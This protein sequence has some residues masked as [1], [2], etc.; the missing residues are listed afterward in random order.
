ME[1]KSDCITVGELFRN[2]RYTFVVP[3]FQRGYSWDDEQIG[4]FC[5]DIEETFLRDASDPSRQHFFGGILG[6]HGR[7]VGVSV[8]TNDVVDGQQRLTTFVLLA[9]RVIR[10]YEALRMRNPEL[11]KAINLRIENL[12]KQYLV[13]EDTEDMVPKEHDRLTLSRYDYDFFKGLITKRDEAPAPARHSHNRLLEA[14]KALDKMLG[15]IL[16]GAK[17]PREK[18]EQLVRLEGVLN[19]C[20]LIVFLATSDRPDAYRV[21]QIM[22]DRGLSLNEADLLRAHTLGHL[23]SAS[24]KRELQEAEGI[25]DN[26]QSDRPEKTKDFLRWYYAAWQGEAPRK[27]ALFDD[28]RRKFFPDRYDATQVVRE[29]RRFHKAV[30]I[31][32]DL[33]QGEWPVI[34]FSPP[35]QWQANRL[36]LLVSSLKHNQCMP[37]LYAACSLRERHFVELVDVL[38]KFFFRYKVICDAHVTPMLQAYLLYAKQICCKAAA[39]R[40]QM[41]RT[42]LQDLLDRRASEQVFRVQLDLMKY[43]QDGGN[44]ELKCLLVT[45]EE[46]WN[47]F[48]NSCRGG[49]VGRLKQEDHARPFDLESTTIEHLYPQRAKQA[50]VDMTLEPVKHGIGNLTILDP[51]TNIADRNLPFVKKRTSLEKSNCLMTREVSEFQQWKLTDV[52]A[53][54]RRLVEAAIRVFAV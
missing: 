41:L 43:D 49:V 34:A 29:L 3:R 8:V 6:S 37:L 30:H 9:S 35:Q 19:E 38:S 50:D 27:G 1:I 33:S 31:L 46:N 2:R 53:W 12:R 25:W 20:C 18:V 45:L 44:R 26:I 10:M 36:R 32:R 52:E 24:T 16:S 21:F 51:N 22:N 47:W 54:G 39:F 5:R 11:E 28:F 17:R 15:R 23:D 13:L 7:E 4:D 40:V 14:R 48:A 42:A